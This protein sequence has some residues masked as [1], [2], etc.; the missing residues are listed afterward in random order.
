VLIQGSGRSGSS[1]IT[2]VISFRLA[3]VSVGWGVGCTVG[4]GVGV[5]GPAGAA[6][7]LVGSGREGVGVDVMPQAIIKIEII[8]AN[9]VVTG[10]HRSFLGGMIFTKQAPPYVR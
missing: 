8:A 2:I 6:V 7:V 10:I 1:L 4:I 5:V 3:A 9:V